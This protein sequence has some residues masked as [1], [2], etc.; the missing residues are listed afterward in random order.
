MFK[1]IFEVA[2]NGSIDDVQF[3]IEQ[4]KRVHA[5]E[6][7]SGWTPLHHAAKTNSNIDVLKYLIEQGANVN[8]K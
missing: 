4:G 8:S 1:N 7:K 3:F 5:K 6:K 2:A